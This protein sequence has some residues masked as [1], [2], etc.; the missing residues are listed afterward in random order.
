MNKLLSIARILIGVFLTIG[1]LDA[2][3]SVINV[4]INNQLSGPVHRT[5]LEGPW[6]TAPSED[7]WQ[8]TQSYAQTDLAF[9]G[10]RKVVYADQVTGQACI[11]QLYGSWSVATGYSLTARATPVWVEGSPAIECS[12]SI[13]RSGNSPVVTF[14]LWSY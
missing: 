1:A 2:Q 3:A 13:N 4:I 7:I 8:N 5:I 9:S 11:F 6:F 12:H 10:N 14:T